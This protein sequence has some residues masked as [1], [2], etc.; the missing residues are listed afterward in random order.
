[1]TKRSAHSPREVYPLALDLRNKRVLVVGGGTVAT[2]RAHSLAH[3]GAIVEV[4]TPWADDAMWA[5]ADAHEVRLTLREYADGDE[6]GAWLVHTCTGDANVDARVAMS[7]EASRIWCVRSDDHQFSAAWVPAVTRHGE[8]T[9]A[10]TSNG[11]PQRSMALRDAISAL[12]ADGTLGERRRRPASHGS[13]W[14]ALVGGGP[15]DP[16][17]ITMRGRELLHQADVVVVDRLAPRALLDELDT[18]VQIIEAGKGPDAHTM[19]QEQIN[20]TIVDRAVGGC[21]VVRLKG[22]DPFV[23]GR[24]GEEVLACAAAG[25]AVEVVP[26]ITSAIAAPAAAGIPVTHRG[27]SSQ[28]T[29]LSAHDDVRAVA[30]AAP[31]QGTL[32]ILMGVGR[33]KDL[34]AGLLASGRDGSTPAAIVERGTLPDQRTVTA[35]LDSL[36]EHAQSA[37]ISSPAVIVIGDVAA[38]AETIGAAASRLTAS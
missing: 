6:R 27:L 24:G 38:L 14:V 31:V 29:V 11:D 23:L 3:A 10:V 18:D 32:L 20:A 2:R 28:F 34:V 25:V 19:T 15:G 12:L 22:G 17:L 4:M 35:T 30:Q 8:V 37:H 7:C 1:M 21:R 33:L 36:V 5:M 16:G 9:V 13:G 26:G